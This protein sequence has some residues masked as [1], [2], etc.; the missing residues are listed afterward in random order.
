[1]ST[2]AI[3]PSLVSP[4]P[5]SARTNRPTPVRLT[6][7]GRFVARLAVVASL[8]ILLLAGASIFTQ[9]SAG[10]E[11]G[12][13]LPTPYV[14]VTVAPGQTLWSI[15]A[16]ITGDGDRR[17]MVDEIVSINHLRSPELFAGQKL[18]IPTR[19]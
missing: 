14:K 5:L 8:S 15:A 6:A 13:A 11:G 19:H 1:M 7:R 16:S 9:A 18:F 12:E 2:V 3:N 4:T 17:D 10:S